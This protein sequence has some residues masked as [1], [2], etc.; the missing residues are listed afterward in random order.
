MVYVLGLGVCVLAEFGRF[1]LYNILVDGEDCNTQE[2]ELEETDEEEFR[3][4]KQM[5]LV[6]QSGEVETGKS[7]LAE[8]L[9]RI[10]HGRKHAIHST[11]SF[12]SAKSLLG[13]GE[14]V[15]IGWLLKQLTL[16][17]TQDN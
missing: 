13:K 2:A 16:F 14:P 3:G 4:Y 5:L 17:I 7:F 1:L 12:E 8:I 9:L 6:L 10:F 11:L 15:V